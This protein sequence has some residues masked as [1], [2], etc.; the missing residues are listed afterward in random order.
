MSGFGV[1]LD[2]TARREVGSRGPGGTDRANTDFSN[3]N[4]MQKPRLGPKLA[5]STTGVGR[6][7]ARG[8]AWDRQVEVCFSGVSGGRTG[9]RGG[10]RGVFG[11]SKDGFGPLLLGW[12]EGTRSG[13]TFGRAVVLE[14][15]ILCTEWASRGDLGGRGHWLA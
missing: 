15:V 13:L 10:G 8:C 9:V 12:S 2:L 3:G 11:P 6:R 1:L 14:G 5:R 4:I 7:G